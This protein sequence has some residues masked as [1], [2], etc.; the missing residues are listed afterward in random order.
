MTDYSIP[1]KTLEPTSVRVEH[2]LIETAR[3]FAGNRAALSGLVMF[4]IIVVVSL[5]GPWLYPTDPFE[6]R[7]SVV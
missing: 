4:L 3:M 1:Q 6:D 7:K 2:P 5:A